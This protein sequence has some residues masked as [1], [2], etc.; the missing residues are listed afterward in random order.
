MVTKKIINVRD[1]IYSWN[2]PSYSVTED[3]VMKN[4]FEFVKET[5][6]NNPSIIGLIAFS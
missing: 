4:A 3:T 2:N 1:K 5:I 6:K